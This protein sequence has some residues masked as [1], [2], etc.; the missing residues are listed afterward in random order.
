MYEDIKSTETKE[1]DENRFL[2]TSDLCVLLKTCPATV[3]QLYK[4]KDFPVLKIGKNY[5]TEY[6]AFMRW[7]SERR[8]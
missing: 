6:N 3:R 4:R 2:S 1:C 8:V 5:K 7:C